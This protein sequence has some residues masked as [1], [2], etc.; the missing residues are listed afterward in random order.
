MRIPTVIILALAVALVGLVLLWL[1]QRRLIY[2]P[3][4]APVL[5]ID[6]RV[7]GA[8]DIRIATRDGLQLGGWLFPPPG[9]NRPI[10]VVVFNGNAGSREARLPLA[11]ALARRGLGVL[12][13]DYR[14]YGGNPGSPTEDGLLRDAHAALDHLASRTDVDLGQI[15]YYGESLGSGVAVRLA[16]DRPPAALVLRSPY[17]SLV[18][19]AKVHYPFLPVSL[20]L[21]DRFATEQRIGGIH[22]PL[23]VIAG[24]RDSVI[25]H[26]QSR[27]V[28]EAAAQQQKRFLSVTGAGHNDVRLTHSEAMIG[29]V[30]SFLS[31]QIGH[32]APEDS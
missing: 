25:P 23:L 31:E 7:A 15:V 11:L 18:D 20:L 30:V 6:G 4:V 22:C 10:T 21:R 5:P 1:G 3:D 26:D 2:Y 9:P 32:T 24:D 28:F 29:D 27:R 14:G 19:V 12:L 13:F 8:I 16:V 17:T